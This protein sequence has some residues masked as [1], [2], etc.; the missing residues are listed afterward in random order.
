MKHLPHDFDKLVAF[1]P[2]EKQFVE[3]LDM[4]R[5]RVD[6]LLVARPSS[7]L[8]VVVMVLCHNLPS[9][10]SVS[11]SIPWL[12]AFEFLNGVV[13]RTEYGQRHISAGILVRLFPHPLGNEVERLSVTTAGPCLKTRQYGF[14]VERKADPNLTLVL[15]EA[16]LAPAGEDWAVFHHRSVLFDASFSVATSRL[17]A[18]ILN[19]VLY[20]AI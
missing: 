6:Q 20:W 18:E 8:G 13:G 4:L 19:P 14:T 10:L 9:H 11:R 16:F 12:L 3:I 7:V 1:A 15:R 2:V 5:P 17:L